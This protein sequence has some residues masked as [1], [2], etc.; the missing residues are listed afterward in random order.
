V[1]TGKSYVSCHPVA[2]YAFRE[3]A[4]LAARGDR[5]FQQERLVG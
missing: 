3:P 4:Q 1:R 5:R 2:V